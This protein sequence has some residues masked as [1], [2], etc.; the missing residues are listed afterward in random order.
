MIIPHAAFL[1]VSGREPLT[2]YM[3][4]SNIKL[5]CLFDVSL[6]SGAARKWEVE[7]TQEEPLFF[8]RCDGQNRQR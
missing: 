8:L 1:S 5:S 3:W 4:G 2:S 7:I 6:I